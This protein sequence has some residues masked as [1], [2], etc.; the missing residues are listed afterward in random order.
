M[1]DER[2]LLDLQARYQNIL[3]KNGG[4]RTLCNSLKQDIKN[5]VFIMDPYYENLL[6]IDRELREKKPDFYDYLNNRELIGR[7][8]RNSLCGKKMNLKESRYSWKGK[9]FSELE[10]K[11]GHDG[12]VLGILAIFLDNRKD[13]A[14]NCCPAIMQAVYALSLKL[15]QNNLIQ[16]LARKCSN[17][18]IE[19]IL[20]DKINDRQE[21]IKRSELAG[22][23]LS[24]P[25]QLFV[26]RYSCEHVTSAEEEQ[27]R[28][29]YKYELEEKIISSLHRIIRTNI[30]R[31]YIIF[32]YDSDILL[33]IN[34]SQPDD[35]RFRDIKKIQAWLQERFSKLDLFLGAG[36][37]IDE[38]T[39]I[40][41]S[42]Q[43][44]LYTITFLQETNQVGNCLFYENLGSLKLL[45]QVEND[46]LKEFAFEYLQAVLESD[47]QNNN[48][49]L[50]TLGI[51]LQENSNFQAA[52]E[53]LHLHPNTIRYRIDKIQELLDC[54]L[55]NFDSQVNLI[56][57]YKI[58][59]FI[60]GKD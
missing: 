45:W 9:T 12:N 8:T 43:Q 42:Y 39:A 30:S 46:K 48:N 34:Y 28:S 10:V 35:T 60:L 21:L 19:D 59:R 52:A 33:L 3:L 56:L 24:V 53:R 58:Y 4:L 14:D 55:K 6:Y 47:R 49:L 57:A 32:S 36:C 2:G 22:W 17:E 25:Y 37:F 16:K 54:D 11:L 26:L 1:T 18:L 29:L 13:F 44:G 27:E 40:S 23:D 51:F 5:P 31:K 50:E 41:Q 7:K 15:H 20:Q 38:C